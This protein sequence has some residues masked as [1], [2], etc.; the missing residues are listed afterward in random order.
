MVVSKSLCFIQKPF[1]SVE[2]LSY[3]YS[4]HGGGPGPIVENDPR[5]I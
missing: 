5:G 4:R 1:L 2:I 3:S